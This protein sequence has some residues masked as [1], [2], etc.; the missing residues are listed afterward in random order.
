MVPCFLFPLHQFFV[1]QI[2]TLLDL[3][4]PITYFTFNYFFW[5]KGLVVP[6]GLQCL[7][8]EAVEKRAMGTKPLRYVDNNW[9][10]IQA[11][12]AFFFLL[13]YMKTLSLQQQE[14]L[15]NRKEC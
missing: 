2:C 15:F 5:D 8:M 3:S 14:D 12:E 11:K 4:H 10:R 6:W 7:C 13:G 1:A 9:V